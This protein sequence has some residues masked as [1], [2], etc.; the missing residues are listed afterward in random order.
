M[1]TN[2]DMATTE[3]EHKIKLQMSSK[4]RLLSSSQKSSGTATSRRFSCSTANVSTVYGEEV[5]RGA[6]SAQ[7]R[8]SRRGFLYGTLFC[9]VA[10]GFDDMSFPPSPLLPEDP[11][12]SVKS[13]DGRLQLEPER[14]SKSLAKKPS[15]QMISSNIKFSLDEILKATDYFS[16]KSLIGE[17]GCSLVYR[18]ELTN[19]KV[20]AIKRSKKDMEDV[21]FVTESFRNEIQTLQQIEHLNLVGFY[22]YLE[23]D[24]EKVI[25]VEYVPNGNLRQHLD[26]VFGKILD[27]AARLDI[28]IDVAHAITYLHTYCDKPII[29]RDIKSSNILLTN[30]LHAKVTDFGFSRLGPNENGATHVQTRVKGTMGYL[31]PEYF[32]TAILTDKSDVFSFGVLLVEMMTGRRPMERRKGRERVTAQWAIEEFEEGRAV[33]TLDPNLE[34]NV[35][36][37]LALE[38]VYELASQCLGETR[39]TR[40]KMKTCGEILWSIRKGYR[41]LLN[42][43]KYNYKCRI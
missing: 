27:F 20:V 36:V 38:Q 17:G 14:L 42:S 28:A 32:K 23:Y 11:E 33:K 19:G 4:K 9:C 22:G 1:K 5:S 29:H 13:A 34:S 6:M 31:D 10:G 2:E 41:D 40:P 3:E 16:K 24:D 21:H 8:R 30:T 26:C 15:F 37:N 39:Q 18:G 25:V 35:A 12:Y 7:Q 43:E